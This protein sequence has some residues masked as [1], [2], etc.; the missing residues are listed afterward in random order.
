MKKLILRWLFG[1]DNINS[2]MELLRENKDHCID[3]L[4]HTNECIELI[5]E[6]RETIN[7][8]EWFIQL[9]EKL[10]RICKNHGIDIDEEIKYIQLDDNNEVNENDGQREVVQDN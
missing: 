7:R 1:T 3:A 6:H 10:I 8:A 9:C 5:R 2:Y 4:K